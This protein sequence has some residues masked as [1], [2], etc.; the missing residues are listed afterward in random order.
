MPDKTPVKISKTFGMKI[1]AE[2]QSY[3][4][5]S[6]MEL[7][8]PKGIDPLSKEDQD[9]ISRCNAWLSTSVIESTISDVKAFAGYNDKF[10]IILAA[11]NKK[12]EELP[13]KIK[14]LAVS[15]TSNMDV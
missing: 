13:K 10:R 4:F 11:R 15:S 1:N 2:Y 8:L 9:Y 12:V 5:S 3:D 7:V 6:T 14:E